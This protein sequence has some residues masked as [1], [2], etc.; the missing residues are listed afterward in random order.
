MTKIK[1]DNNFNKSMVKTLKFIKFN[2]N[3]IKNNMFQI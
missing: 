1:L 3:R 2:K